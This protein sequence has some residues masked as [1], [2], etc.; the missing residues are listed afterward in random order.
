MAVLGPDTQTVDTPSNAAENNPALLAGPAH[1]DYW[2]AL[3]MTSLLA[4][5]KEP[6]LSPQYGSAL[7]AIMTINRSLRRR[8][9]PY[10]PQVRSPCTA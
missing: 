2:L 10:W 8:C 7:E 4:I 5:L 1:E 9:A 6:S 3:T